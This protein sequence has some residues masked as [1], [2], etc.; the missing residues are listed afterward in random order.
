MCTTTSDTVSASNTVI[1][2][3]NQI[4]LLNSVLRVRILLLLLSLIQHVLL[5]KSK[6]IEVSLNPVLLRPMTNLILLLHLL[7]RILR[8]SKWKKKKNDSFPNSSVVFG[9]VPCNITYNNNNNNIYEFVPN[10][11]NND[12][13]TVRDVNKQTTH[14]VHQSLFYIYEVNTNYDNINTILNNNFNVC[15]DTACG[16][17]I[18]HNGVDAIF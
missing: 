12:F 16:G 18:F 13:D 10:N 15:D 2:L 3:L 1:E 17:G 14:Q 6:K 4:L 7:L 8:V 9:Q 11:S 5:T